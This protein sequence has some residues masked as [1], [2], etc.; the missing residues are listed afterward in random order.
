MRNITAFYHVYRSEERKK[1]V[2]WS[3]TGSC[4]LHA[5][6]FRRSIIA[7]NL[8]QFHLNFS[9]SLKTIFAF[10][11]YVNDIILIIEW[12]NLMLSGKRCTNF[13]T[14]KNIAA[15]TNFGVPTN[16]YLETIL[17]SIKIR[18]LQID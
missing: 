17:I 14:W 18:R 5:S 3:C 2:F 10:S 6:I 9:L 4:N 12:L 13:L 11:F 8:G 16:V 7:E 15:K 1:P